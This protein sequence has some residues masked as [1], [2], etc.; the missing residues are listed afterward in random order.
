[1]IALVC[2]LAAAISHSQQPLAPTPPLGWNS[3]DSYGLTITEQQFRSN[4]AVEAEKLK[5]F[6]YTYA[7]IDEGWFLR[8]PL[9]RPHPELLQYEL[10]A[11]GRYIPVPARFPSA[12]V[13][14]EN[15][16]FAQ[17]ASWVHAQGLKFGIHIVR[18]IPRESV[19]QN[20]PIEA[21][22]FRASDAADTSDA[23]PWDPTNWGIK[24]NAAGQAW[25]DALL[26]QYAAWGVDLLKVDC[27]ADHPY[28]PAEIQQIQ[29]AIKRS[30]RPIVLSLSPGPT[31]I[32]HADEVASLS[33]MWRIS[34]DIWDVWQSA[35]PFPRS[36]KSQFDT[37]AAWA[38]HARPGAWP[39]A[40][41]LP[42][43]EL[44]PH[45]DVG[46]G[47]RKT[48]LSP[49]EQRTMVTLWSMARSP[50]ILGANLTLLD[51][52]TIKLLTDRDLIRIDQLAS[53]SH[54][55]WRED[56]LVAWTADLPGN[57]R[58]LAVFNLGEIAQ[59]PAKLLAEHG[60][61]L[62]KYHVRD[63]T[64]APGTSPLTASTQIPPHGSMLLLGRAS[65]TH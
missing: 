36:V 62:S 32:E 6:G 37:A 34:D 55:S 11:N 45:P 4:V 38:P 22:A 20:L 30:G 28:K 43:G 49:I 59:S 51:A 8:N 58:A 15:T 47:P 27:I 7:V 41:M 25:Y 17:I 44:R 13:S 24:A 23:C 18:G 63:A 46:P 57:N 12:L 65:P 35:T 60:L 3:W 42:L 31:A 19:R 52:D 56:D 48:R 2:L 5:A 26:K 14:G 64:G 39:D 29:L 1:M 61:G 40:D 33:Q 16:G 53:N 54:Q 50:L 21:S 9:D 10:D